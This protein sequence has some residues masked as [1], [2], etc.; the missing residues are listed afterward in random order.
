MTEEEL[1]TLNVQLRSAE[2]YIFTF[3]FIFAT[4]GNTLVL[5]A[6]W[7]EK[8]LHQPNK[9]FVA[10]LA[11]ADLLIGT[12][13]IPLRLYFVEPISH[14]LHLCRFYIWIEAFALAASVFTLAFIS[15]DRYLKISKPLQ[16]ESRMTT[17][18]SVKIISIMVLICTGITIICMLPLGGASG[19]ILKNSQVDTICYLDMN[20]LVYTL[21]TVSIAFVPTI[22]MVIMYL[23]IFLVAHKRHRMLRNGELS[24]AT[25]NVRSAFLLD[26]KVIR[27]MIT[28][29]GVFIFC[30][31]PWLVMNMISEY[32]PDFG[33]NKREGLIFETVTFVLPYFNSLCNPIIY[34]CFDRTYREAFKHLFKQPMCRRGSRRQ[35]PPDTIKLSP[36]RAK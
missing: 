33:A 13:V 29:V 21:Y 10:C 28:V 9:Y 30:W 7:R 15:Y 20:E 23:R 18:K 16:Y 3:T 31:F 24:H 25:S 34:A 26:L 6:T 11:V 5:V 14:N 32:H 17:S 36:Q 22:F 35:Q 12:I 4:I 2:Y 1:Y 19:V 27:M 8:R